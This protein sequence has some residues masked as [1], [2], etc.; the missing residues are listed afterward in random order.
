MESTCGAAND[1]ARED[2]SENVMLMAESCDHKYVRELPSGSE[3][4]P[5]RATVEP[6]WTVWESPASTTGGL[7]AGWSGAVPATVTV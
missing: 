3:A 6:S 7:L 5:L 4:V 1:A 2:G